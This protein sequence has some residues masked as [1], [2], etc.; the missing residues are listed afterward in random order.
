M[1]NFGLGFIKQRTKMEAE[2]KYE[3]RK[4][5]EIVFSKVIKAGKRIYYVDVKENRHGEMYLALTESKK[6]VS[7]D[8]YNQQVS[9]EKHKVFLYREDFEKFLA[10]LHEAVD[11]IEE[12]QGKAEPRPERND[13]IKIDLEF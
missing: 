6:V 12:Q 5:R 9:F 1:S 10:E 4:E 2:N 8:E 3:D 11:F 7:G 13:D